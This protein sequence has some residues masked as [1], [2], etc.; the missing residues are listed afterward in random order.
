[1]TTHP[2]VRNSCAAAVY[3]TVFMLAVFAALY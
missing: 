2:S 1:M 3:L